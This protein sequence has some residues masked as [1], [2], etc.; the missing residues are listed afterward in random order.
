[1]LVAVLPLSIKARKLSGVQTGAAL[2]AL[3]GS[4]RA[5]DCII[6]KL[7]DILVK[8]GMADS[9]LFHMLEK[10][11][12]GIA[13]GLS[14]LPALIVDHSLLLNS[15]AIIWLLVRA[16]RAF[17]P[18]YR[19]GPL[20]VMCL[21]AAQIVSSWIRSPQDINASY[22]KFLY[23]ASGKPASL[24]RVFAENGSN[25]VFPHI[26]DVHS[27]LSCHKHAITFFL[28]GL[29]LG[30]PMYFPIHLLSFVMARRKNPGIFLEN[31]L[32]SCSFVSLYVTL[33]YVATCSF[34][35]LFPGVSRSHLLLCGWLPGLAVLLEHPARQKEL[36]A[37]CLTQALDITYHFLCRKGMMVPSNV[38]GVLLLVGALGTI[39]QNHNQQPK[40]I[41]SQLFGIEEKV[42]I[43]SKKSEKTA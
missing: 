4:F 34:F 29:K 18:S 17:V 28:Q 11:A 30:L 10:Y 2:G 9:W 15:T 16:I 12:M 21:S 36:A 25:A 33:A 40:M 23:Y 38:M 5:L 19:Y 1:M 37:Y 39:M 7:R 22:L 24:F 31:M 8:Y 27:G 14:V 26:C 35:R 32:R 41:M 3:L 13:G 6:G 20:L 43:S 42:L